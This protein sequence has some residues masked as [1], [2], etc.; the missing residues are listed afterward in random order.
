MSM[1]DEY[2]ELQRRFN[3]VRQ[4][5]QFL[6]TSH[7]RLTTA[8]SMDKDISQRIRWRIQLHNKIVQSYEDLLNKLEE[9][10]SEIDRMS[11]FE[12]ERIELENKTYELE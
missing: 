12:E 10:K 3:E 6:E 9:Y 4:E 2:K 8:L 7:G 1:P 11:D 5:W